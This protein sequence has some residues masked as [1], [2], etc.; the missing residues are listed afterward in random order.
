MLTEAQ[1]LILSK[2][3]VVCLKEKWNKNTYGHGK[4]NINLHSWFIEFQQNCSAGCSEGFLW[5]ELVTVQL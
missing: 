5:S 4:G 1:N 3:V 2:V